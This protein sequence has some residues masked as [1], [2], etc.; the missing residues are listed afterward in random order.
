MDVLS[1]YPRWSPLL[2]PFLG[3]QRFFLFGFPLSIVIMDF[4]GRVAAPAWSFFDALL[5]KGDVEAVPSNLSGSGD[6]P[7]NSQY[8]AL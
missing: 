3:F 2:R 5:S 1:G 8:P 4:L 6:V 7:E